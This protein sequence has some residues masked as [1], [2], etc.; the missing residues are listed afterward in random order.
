VG[1]SLS[2]ATVGFAVAVPS[3]GLLPVAAGA[4]TYQATVLANSP[5]AYWRLNDAGP[6]AADA[7]GG[8][9]SCSAGGSPSW[10]A[11]GLVPS[12][13][14]TA[15]ALGSSSNYLTCP[16]FNLNGSTAT[17]EAWIKEPATVTTGTIAGLT[18]SGSAF[19]L[20]Q[21]S[22]G[23]LS[24]GLNTTSGGIGFVSSG[25]AMQPSTVY[26]IDGVFSSGT[27]QLYLNGSLIAV[28]SKSGT[29]TANAAFG[30]GFSS[31]GFSGTIG[32]VAVYN[33]A[34]S[35]AQIAAD[36]DAGDPGSVPS[37]AYSSGVVARSPVG[38][39]RL[40]DT[41]GSAFAR[42]AASGS[43]CMSEGSPTFGST[44]LLPATSVSSAAVGSGANYLACPWLDLSGSAATVEAWVK[45]PA[46]VTAGSIAGIGTF[47]AAFGLYQDSS[48]NLSLGLNTTSGGIGF[49]S[50][51]AAMQPSTVYQVVG[52]FSS[53]T[54]SLYVD[55][56]L[57]G[58]SSLSGTLTSQ[59]EFYI[60][61]WSGGFTG[62]IGE[63][64][65]YHS[66]L[67]G[68]QIA[69][70]FD[71]GHPGSVPSDAYSSGVLAKSPVGY[72]RLGDTAGSSFARGV[73]S[74]SNCMSEGSPT[75]GSTGLLSTT[76][77]TAV[78]IGS[79]ANY[80]ACPWLDLRGSAATIDAWV[81]QP[82]TVTAGSI[83]GI[84][85]FG[86]A[87][88][89][90]Q[91]SSGNLSLG[92]NTTSG[93]I[94]FVSSGAAMQ[95]S[96]VYHVTGV[97]SSG[98]LSLYIN[99]TPIGVASQSGTLT[100]LGEFYIGSWSGGFTGTIGEVAVYNYALSAAQIAADS[101]AG[102]FQPAPIGG[103]PTT[104]EMFAD[105]NSC[106]TC[107]AHGDVSSRGDPIDSENGNFW[108]AFDDL[109]VP[110]RGF[111]LDVGRVYNSLA[112][113][114]DGPF[115]YGWSSNL[116][117]S[118]A[119]SGSTATIT[120]ETGSQVTFTLS[121]STWSPSLPRT[122][123][124]LVHNGTGTWTFT[125]Q[126]R[127]TFTFN[128]S[129]QLT[130]ETDLNGYTTTLA[131]SSGKLSSITDPASRSLTIAW[132]GTHITSVTDANV[133][134][135]RTVNYE[136]NDGNGN[137]TDVI[138]VNGGQTHYVYDG[139]HRM[140]VMQDPQ[141]YATSGCPGVQNHYDGSGRVDWQK[142]QLN[143]ETTFAY[144]GTPSTL[145]GGTTTITDPAGNVTVDTFQYALRVASIAGYGTAAAATT[146][147]GYDPVTLAPTL[148]V[149][150]N[151]NATRSTYDSSGNLL[152]TTDPLGH[153][154]YA[155]YN[156]LDE[157][158]TETDAKNVTTTMT[159]DPNGNLLTRSTPL[160]GS[161]PAQTQQTSY[162]YG[163]ATHPGDVT[164][165]TDP[166]SKNWDYTYDTYGDLQSTTD[167][168]SNE[169]TSTYNAD[170][171]KMTDVSAK[172]N[173]SGCSCAAT[174]TTTYGYTIPGGSTLDEFGDVQTV[175]DP[176]SHVTTYGYDADRNRTSVIDP[177]G[178]TTTHVFDLANE[179]HQT[180]R[181]DS[182]QTTLTTDYNTDGTV[183]DQK[184][185]KGH[186]IQTYGYDSLGRVTSTTDADSNTTTY[187]LDNDGNIIAKQD[188]G[189]NC[190]AMP[191]TGC[192]TYTYD[193]DNEPTSVTYSDGT[194]PNVSNMTYDADGQRIAMTDGTGTS[195]WTYDSLHRTVSTTNGASQT[196]GYT[197]D[198]RDMPTTIT[199]PGSHNVTY[200]Y[201]DAG[202]MHTV[203]DWL[204]N[205][206]TIDYD[207]N[208]NIATET[209]PSSPNL[210]DTFTDNAA[211]QL[212]NI[213]DVASG[214]TLFSATYT[215]DSDGQ[216]SSDNSVSGSTGAFKYDALNQLCYAG[217][218]TTNACSS[219]PSA[220]TAYAFDAADNLTTNNGTTQQFD[221]ADRLCWTIAGTSANTCASPPTGATTYSYDNRG[222]RT[223]ITPHTGTA[224]SLGYDQA[225][226]LDS[227][228]G[229]A[230]ATY[231]YDGNGLRST[232]TTGGATTHYTWGT[233]QVPNLLQE[234]T[235]S[236]TTSYIYGPDGLE[237]TPV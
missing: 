118:L 25:A 227:V 195:T 32:E 153:V 120:Q 168:N 147:F 123:A 19:A 13:S 109:T 40:G 125:R 131:Y 165:M 226:Q 81:K 164:E 141:C 142:D 89:L 114:T 67:S 192:T 148:V 46:T 4:T 61:S 64:A 35:G 75:F 222:N 121:G 78:S 139:S 169:T 65:V 29:L 137:L 229:P 217:S 171:W 132:T 72:W 38:Y 166:D 213:A 225:N 199:Y 68:A 185:G 17:I 55:G 74:G 15:V 57:I 88:G 196:V 175:T 63:V 144:A 34:L 188:P 138:D 14:D 83:A 12:S 80:L 204:S 5:L 7:T 97:F 212:T 21:D 66:A 90:Y 11:A 6:T 93:G 221:A 145:A 116:F 172:G 186:A 198:L 179:P 51:G 33:T 236:N 82:A 112:A 130:A 231:A 128:S 101:A 47:G 23:D 178:N 124:T 150:P 206:T 161:S 41:A 49:V 193:A 134:P 96:T 210:V 184:D 215:R 157:P 87:F 105:G 37:D 22:S 70:D 43:N 207:H 24:L 200:A 143:R 182:P 216:L 20:Y 127:D 135:N 94:G 103:A 79:G 95:P 48:G 219:P 129:G 56:T 160:V 237:V 50:S 122:I 190:A 230:S 152:S 117:P 194:T 223:A 59:G 108:E 191:K 77:Q 54:L 52:V 224:T 203:T 173:V 162:T 205:T 201:D 107:M 86:A 99:G 151:G 3:L 183:A 140:T 211:D 42:G 158:L 126:K 156:A 85:T 197:Y 27:L 154:T 2:L 177:N 69:G 234:T 214:S 113:S 26:Q 110:G 133:T 91:D 189:G 174:Y 180:Q 36:F 146:R 10:S 181:A 136:Y 102:G 31:G 8:G 98:T 45:Q 104:A 9:H 84:G 30:I 53:G 60:G 176:L 71:A 220:A 1:L 119:V 62:T 16:S 76:S 111:P 28:G 209:F 100:S 187:T 228:I 115:G 202:R 170:G 233:D 218:A 208:S 18:A 39:W 58:V 167:P 155:T 159:Y 235:S 163:D 149:D 44:G 106:W 73:A 232:K 92:L